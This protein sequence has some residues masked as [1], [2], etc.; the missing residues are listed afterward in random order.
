[1][2]DN[3]AEPLA[4]AGW[5]DFSLYRPHPA[6]ARLRD[7]LAEA[8][9]LTRELTQFLEGACLDVPMLEIVNPPLWELGHIAWFQ[10]FWLHRGGNFAARSM[11]PQADRWYDS[12]RVAHATRWSLDLPD[13]AATRAYVEAVFGRTQSLLEGEALSDARAYFA[14]LALF[15][16]DMHNEAFCYMWQTLGYRMPVAWPEAGASNA[17]DIDMPACAMTIGARPGSGFVFD[18]EKWAHELSLPAFA[19]ARRA[20][21]N[22]EYTAFVDDGGYARRELWSDA[23]WAMRD[24]LALAHPRYWRRDREG[25]S[26]RRFDRWPPLAVHEPV[27]HVS[28]HEA[29]AYCAWA[30]RRLPSEAEWECAAGSRSDRFDCGRVWEWTSSRFGPY[31]G[32]SAD[33]YKEYS[34]PWFAEEHRVLRG[35]SFATPARLLRTTWRNFYQPERADM[36]CGFRTCAI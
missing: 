19:I 32:F 6:A 3:I 26:V 12:A 34:A 18:N 16:Q 13:A 25:W 28:W 29:L 31:P 22:A 9:T 27:M 21:S 4:R 24:R 10:E 7:W 23:G 1:M 33:P 17:A 8:H 11:L 5:P 20:V 30:G 35:G 15:H 14:Q 36:F 2:S